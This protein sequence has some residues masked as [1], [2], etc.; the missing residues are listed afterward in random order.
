MIVRFLEFVRS[1]EAANRG[2]L[3]N[4]LA[5]LGKDLVGAMVR[6]PSL[7]IGKITDLLIDVEDD[8]V[9]YLVTN[10]TV[11]NRYPAI[12]PL[13]YLRWFDSKKRI[14]FLSIGLKQLSSYP[15]FDPK[16]FGSWEHKVFMSFFD[17]YDPA[18]ESE[19]I[20]RSTKKF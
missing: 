13:A 10:L 19:T 11:R 3:P 1:K 14:A 7:D 6:T 12:V 5:R 4:A 18:R 2:Q 9:L 15:A 16:V 8:T 20:Y 17:D